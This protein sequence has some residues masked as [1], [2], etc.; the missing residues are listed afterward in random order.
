MIP[1]FLASGLT[2][3]WMGVHLFAGGPQ[4]AAPLRNSTEL[5]SVARDTAYL[6][7]H[8]VSVT[9][10]LMAA[11]FGLAAMTGQPG[12]AMAATLLAAGFTVIGIGLPSAIGQKWRVLPQGWLFLP[13]TVL[14]L[15]GMWS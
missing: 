4:I 13:V 5:P 3:L 8:F 7:W 1:L 6:C 12:L 10:G 9:L 11:F 2:A 15:W 14:G